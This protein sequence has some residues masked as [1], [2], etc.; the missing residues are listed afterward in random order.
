MFAVVSADLAALAGVGA[1]L[2][3]GALAVEA[4]ALA[5]VTEL[6]AVGAGDL[7]AAGLLLA[8]V[9]AGFK[10]EAVLTG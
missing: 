1:V 5:C 9:V 10:V 4:D 6:D 3:A 8:V 7:A 2:G